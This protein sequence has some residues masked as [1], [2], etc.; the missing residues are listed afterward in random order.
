MPKRVVILGAG[1]AGMNVARHL[2]RFS[3]PDEVAV[4]VVNRE[5]YMLFT[6][7]L[8]EVS[9]GSIEPRHIAAPLRA[10]LRK[11]AFELGEVTGV[12]FAAR[13]VALRRR[14]GEG[15]ASLPFDQLVVALGAENSTHGVPGAEEHTFPLK[16]LRD[17][18]ALRDVTITAL[19]N[20]ATSTNDGE[21][22]SLTTFV[23]VGGGFTGVE[24]AGELLAFLRSAARFYP[25]V[26]TNDVRIVLVAGSDR[27]LEQ[28]SP[29][30]GK[31]AHDML[32]R[33]GVDVVL[34][35]EV[36]AV[37]AGGISLASG[38]R[39]ETRCVVWS[40]GVRPSPLAAKL[41]L[42][43]SKHHAIVVNADLSVKGTP[44]VWALGDCAQIP[45]PGGGSYPQTAQHA[46]HEAKRLARNLLAKLRERETKPY[47]YRARGMMA[48]LGA[49]EGLAEI[50]GRITLSGLPAWSLWRAYYLWQLPGNDR[51]ARVALDWSLN[52]PFP[53]DIASVR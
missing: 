1:F 43:H 7:M 8:P 6:P 10:I 14:G 40:A 3:R 41:D 15:D 22:R 36:A 28:L 12:D 48:S 13:T 35:D 2:E 50:G 32:G 44:D 27:L 21:R 34:R 53:A 16:T 30:L 24:A 42:A 49:H 51:K 47:A 17:A 4:T 52:F 11:T 46:V 19:E 31:L 5:N 20:A 23:V 29:A 25:R 26:E 33:R 39:Y 38:K 18:V 45:K 37:D 9:S